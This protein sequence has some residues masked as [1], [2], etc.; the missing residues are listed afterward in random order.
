MFFNCPNCIILVFKPPKTVKFDFRDSI[1]TYYVLPLR[2]S[3]SLIKSI[4]LITL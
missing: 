3:E 2:T 1:K 4:L